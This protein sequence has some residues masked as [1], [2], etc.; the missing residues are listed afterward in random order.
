MKR[1]VF[2]YGSVLAFTSPVSATAQQPGKVY[3]IGIL[4]AILSVDMVRTALRTE[5]FTLVFVQALRELGWVEGQNF[6]FEIVSADG[7]RERLPALAAELVRRKVDLILVN[8]TQT[9]IAAKGATA[10]IPIVILGSGDAVEGE[11]ASSL[12]RPGG[13]VTGISS[14][15]SDLISAGPSLVSNPW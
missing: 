4:S 7:R 1:R 2:L 12:A 13:N 11:L 15:T 5:P 14:L 6:V 8:N 9:T 3:R 10:T